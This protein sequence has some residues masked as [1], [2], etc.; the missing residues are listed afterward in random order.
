MVSCVSVYVIISANPN[1]PW[2]DGRL[3]YP[4]IIMIVAGKTLANPVITH[5]LPFWT[6]QPIYPDR[7]DLA[8][9]KEPFAYALRQYEY[10]FVTELGKLISIV[11]VSGI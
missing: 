10:I 1:Y 7:P 11:P 9:S 5:L 3:M 2:V 4:L 6:A 8:K